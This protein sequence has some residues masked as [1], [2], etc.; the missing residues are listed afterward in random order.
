MILS[1][2]NHNYLKAHQRIGGLFIKDIIFTLIG[3]WFEL[4]SN[5]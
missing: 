1:I 5:C 4:S 2:V 3:E